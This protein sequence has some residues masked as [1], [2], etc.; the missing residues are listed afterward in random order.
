MKRFG[1]S[2]LLPV[3]LAAACGGDGKAPLLGTLAPAANAAKDG[4]VNG[5]TCESNEQFI[6]H[7]HT[8]LTIFDHGVQKLLP[9][10]IGITPGKCFSW[11][12]T[13]DQ[14]GIIHIESPTQRTFTLGDFFSVWAQPLDKNTVGPVQGTVTATV[15]GVV[16]NDD[17]RMVP[18]G[19][20]SLVQLDI[21]EPVVGP[22]PY[23]FPPGY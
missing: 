9:S 4:P 2:F 7:I 15:D 17:P 11:L 16:F 20:R 6:L 14:T 13:H 10:E 1:F 8:H 12:H 22:Q 18:L 21:G 19:N 3:T 5:I 23:T